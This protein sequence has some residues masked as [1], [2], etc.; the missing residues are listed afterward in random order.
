[1]TKRSITNRT[2]LAVV[3][4]TALL[5]GWPTESRAQDVPKSAITMSYRNL[6]LSRNPERAKGRKN[7]DALNNDT[8]RYELVFRNPTTVALRNV[9]FENPLPPNLILVGGSATTSTAAVI[10]YSADGGK[11][12]AVAPKIREVVEG[13]QVERVAVPEEFTH[14][15]WT[16]T[17]EVEPNATVT[18]RYDV[19]VGA[20]SRQ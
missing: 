7:G 1:M 14:I 18:A 2:S 3:L 10:E 5:L 15:R 16:V 6:T 17:G 20:R 9:V 8:L 4:V 12:F 13:K 19:R 11:S